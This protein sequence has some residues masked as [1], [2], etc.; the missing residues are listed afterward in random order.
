MLMLNKWLSD[1]RRSSTTI[2]RTFFF[3][4][5][6]IMFVWAKKLQKIILFP[7]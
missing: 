2:D 4:R 5:C 7:V 6:D 3:E 1:A